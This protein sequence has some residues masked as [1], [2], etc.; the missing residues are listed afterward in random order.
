[1]SHATMSFPALYDYAKS[2][3]NIDIFED[4]SLPAS[5]DKDTLVDFILMRSAPFE[6]LYT[7]PVYMKAAVTTWAQVHSRTFTKWMDA[8][9]LEY[10]P[11]HNYDRTEEGNDTDIENRILKD[12]T[13]SSLS[14]RATTLGNNSDNTKTDSTT[15]NSVSAYDS[16]TFSDSDKSVTGSGTGSTNTNLNDTMNKEKSNVAS[17]ENENKLNTRAHKLRAFGNIGVTTSMQLIESELSLDAWNVYEHITD[18][19]MDEFCV[20]LY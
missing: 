3:E 6:V 8:L 5:I 13:D 18:L 16:A 12:K 11:L 20:L 17:A 4:V 9:S 10:N 2:V 7:D 14:S 19:F 1:M 15:T